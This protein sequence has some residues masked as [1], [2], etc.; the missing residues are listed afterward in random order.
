M[1][2]PS[3]LHQY[4]AIAAFMKARG[5]FLSS[6]SITLSILAGIAKK[7][8]ADVDRK[9]PLYD[10][11]CNRVE[12]EHQSLGKLRELLDSYKVIKDSPLFKKTHKF[13]LYMLSLGL[14]ENF[15][16][17]FDSLGFSKY[18][19]KMIRNTHRPCFDMIYCIADTILFVCERGKSIVTGKQI[20]RAH[21]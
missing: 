18:E 10:E 11:I 3:E 14:L 16:V 12:W 21:V 4:V 1:I 15:N 2:S 9:D 5:S 7:L 17:S 8:F 13:T 20:G 6:T 19:E